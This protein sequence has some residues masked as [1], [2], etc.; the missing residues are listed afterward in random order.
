MKSKKIFTAAEKYK[1]SM[2][3]IKG[4]MSIAQIASHYGVHPTQIHQWKK[5]AL[6]YLIA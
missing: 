5:E 6:I 4:V 2:E 3:A 1:V